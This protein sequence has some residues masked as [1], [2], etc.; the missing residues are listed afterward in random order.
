MVKKLFFLLIIIICNPVFL[1]AQN[2]LVSGTVSDAADSLPLPGVSII[3]PGIKHGTYTDSS[4]YFRLYVPQT[5]D[6]L[7]FMY[8]GYVT[9]KVSIHE[10]SSLKIALRKQ[11]NPFT[12]IGNP[13]FRLNKFWNTSSTA[14]TINPD[15]Y[16]LPLTNYEQILFAKESGIYV[17]NTDLTGY[18]NLTFIRGTSRERINNQPLFV[19]NGFPLIT[20]IAEPGLYPFNPSDVLYNPFRNLASPDIQSVT[21]LKGE[22]VTS[23]EDQ[24]SSNGAILINMKHGKSGKP[25]VHIGFNV[26]SNNRSDINKTNSY[27]GISGGNKVVQYYVS[28]ILGYDN[29]SGYLPSGNRKTALV[30]LQSNKNRRFSTHFFLTASQNKGLDK[31]NFNNQFHQEQLISTA[32]ANYQIIPG[33]LKYN[34]LLGLQQSILGSGGK[35][36]PTMHL[37]INNYDWSNLFD[38]SQSWGVNILHINEGNSLQHATLKNSN[39]LAPLVNNQS[40]NASEYLQNNFIRFNY[41]Y[42]HKLIVTFKS[43][44]NGIYGANNVRHY[45]FYPSVYAGWV[46]SMEPYIVAI[47]PINF[48]KFYTQYGRT[49]NQNINTFIPSTGNSSV[50]VPGELE[51]LYNQSVNFNLGMDFILFNQ[52]VQGDVIYFS[53]KTIDDSHDEIEPFLNLVN[54]GTECNV[55]VRLLTKPGFSWSIN[56][57]VTFSKLRYSIITNKDMSLS[58][59]SNLLNEQPGHLIPKTYGGFSTEIRFANVDLDIYFHSNQNDIISPNIS[60]TVIGSFNNALDLRTSFDS[61]P[62]LNFNQFLNKYSGTVNS[63]ASLWLQDVNFNYK[64]PGKIV[65][66]FKLKVDICVKNLFKLTKSNVASDRITTNGITNYNLLTFHPMPLRRSVTLGIDLLF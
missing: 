24:N 28:G 8:I 17:T 27:A 62:S 30:D 35:E 32:D 43:K 5:T 9:K 15:V 44:F 4:G 66:N 11:S 41:S 12:E 58:I 2:R 36:I 54:S 19:L 6:S 46:A 10:L 57:N 13:H 65:N 26:T 3:I 53:S 51:N 21:V 47:K 33:I 42:E 18:S 40:W 64:I 60:N 45:S 61:A 56:G 59:A 22:T 14:A 38:Y 39:Y 50:F 37:H 1:I 63:M 29:D 20:H 23:L 48:L 25:K 16:N 49:D 7:M 31:T 34:T 52:R 55:N